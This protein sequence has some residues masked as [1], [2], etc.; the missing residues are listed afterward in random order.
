MSHLRVAHIFMISNI[1]QKTSRIQN[2][3]IIVSFGDYDGS[4]KTLA[5]GAYFN[6]QHYLQ[7]QLVVHKHEFEA[8]HNFTAL[9]ILQTRKE[10]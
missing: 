7:N 6:H 9:S 3:I 8:V 4:K 10:Q 5:K 1:L 2:E